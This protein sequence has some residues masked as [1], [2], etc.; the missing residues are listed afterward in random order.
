MAPGRP[1]PAIREH[2]LVPAWLANAAAPRAGG[3]ELC[4]VL[5]R[6]ADAC[7]DTNPHPFSFPDNVLLYRLGVLGMRGRHQCY[8][9]S[10]L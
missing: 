6:E 9:A 10:L 4:S 1:S 3:R 8:G 7:T 2:V 5:W